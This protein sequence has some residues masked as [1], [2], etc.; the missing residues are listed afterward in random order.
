MLPATIL[1]NGGKHSSRQCWDRDSNDRQ[2]WLIWTT[3]KNIAQR[4][5]WPPFPWGVLCSPLPSASC[6]QRYSHSW[7]LHLLWNYP[8]GW[9]A[10]MHLESEWCGLNGRF[11]PL[12]S[13]EDIELRFPTS[14]EV[15]QP[16]GGETKGKGQYPSLEIMQLSNVWWA[17]FCCVRDVQAFPPLSSFGKLISGCRRRGAWDRSAG[18]SRKETCTL[19]TSSKKLSWGGES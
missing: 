15:P 2:P 13:D 17:W 9:L 19:E 11:E 18:V 10:G 1:A 14:W 12:P 4:T 5:Q 8:P 7:G 3:S 6:T 16:G